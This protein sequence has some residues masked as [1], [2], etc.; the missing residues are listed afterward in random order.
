MRSRRRIALLLASAGA[1]G[2]GLIAFP[3]SA[4]AAPPAGADLYVPGHRG[5]RFLRDGSD[6]RGRPADRSGAREHPPGHPGSLA[7]QPG[8]QRDDQREPAVRRADR[9]QPARGSR[10]VPPRSGRARPSPQAY[11]QCGPGADGTPATEGNAYLSPAG[12]GQREWVHDPAGEALTALHDDL[13]GCRPTTPSRSTRALRWP[14]R[15]PG[16]TARRRNTGG[17]ATRDLHGL[18]DAS[19]RVLDVRLDAQRPQHRHGES[20]P[21]RLLRDRYAW[22]RLPGAVRDQ[23]PERPQDAGD[24]GLHRWWRCDRIARRDVHACPH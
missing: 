11:E 4:A 13:Q 22:S 1:L 17:S 19:A 3:A 14:T 21:G 6:H 5:E 20:R 10:P 8:D 9:A 16:A 15:R 24:L 18:A 2:V 7:V 12:S 23:K